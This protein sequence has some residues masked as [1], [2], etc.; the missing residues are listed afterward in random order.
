LLRKLEDEA[1]LEY[2]A[3]RR[4]LDNEPEPQRDLANYRAQLLTDRFISQE[5]VA[6]LPPITAEDY[7]AYYE[8][9]KDEFVVPEKVEVYLVALPNREELNAL[10]EEIAAGGDIVDINEA[11]NQARGRELMDMYEAP[12]V[13]PPEEQEWRGVVA[14]TREPDAERPDGPFAKELRS[15]LFPF[16]PNGPGGLRQ[17][18]EVFE[19]GDGRGAFYE[20]LYY[21]PRLQ[22]TLDDAGTILKCQ[23]KAWAEYYAGEEV[24]KRSREWLAGLRAGHDV[25][26]HAEKYE[27]AAAHLS[28]AGN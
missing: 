13:L 14:V 10:H 25:I 22:E 26:T 9:H 5:F 1:L 17:L 6:K 12:P 4:G 23:K 19:L 7:T 28:G 27:A 20:P 2:E 15:R 24:Q 8:A 11:I 18:T 16:D 3:L 21:R